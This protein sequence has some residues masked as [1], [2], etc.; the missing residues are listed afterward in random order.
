MSDYRMTTRVG[1]CIHCGRATVQTCTGCER[2]VCEA[3]VPQHD[4]AATP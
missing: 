4:R 1:A 3:C 2:F